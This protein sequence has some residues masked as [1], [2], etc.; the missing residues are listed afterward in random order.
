MGEDAE[1][2]AAEQAAAQTA[3]AAEAD[4]AAILA[5]KKSREE[6]EAKRAAA[7]EKVRAAFMSPVRNVDALKHLADSK[8]DE[9]IENHHANLLKIKP[10]LI[11]SKQVREKTTVKD[12]FDFER[13]DGASTSVPARDAWT[14]M[15][16]DR[17]AQSQRRGRSKT[18]RLLSRGE[19]PWN[20]RRLIERF[21]RESIRC[22]Q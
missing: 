1:R 3:A 17:N 6:A 18:R 7:K 11:N 16:A 10:K 15:I 20:G 4:R 9:K 12:P 14:K 8:V 22:E 21:M 19:T 2:K 5:A 13:C